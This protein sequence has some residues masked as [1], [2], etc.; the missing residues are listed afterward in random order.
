MAMVS[1]M[2]QVSNKLRFYIK[3]GDEPK[4]VSF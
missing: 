1:K 4:I 2:R 3:L